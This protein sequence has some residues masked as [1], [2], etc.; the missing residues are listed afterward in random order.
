MIL[1]VAAIVNADFQASLGFVLALRS[2]LI[3]EMFQ[4]FNFR[5]VLQ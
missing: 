5:M 3:G 1:V 2:I 4:A